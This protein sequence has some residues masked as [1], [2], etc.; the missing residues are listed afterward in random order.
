P[1]R[2][3]TEHHSGAFSMRL[4]GQVRSASARGRNGR[5]FSKGI[6]FGVTGWGGMLVPLVV[7]PCLVRARKRRNLLA[8][9]AGGRTSAYVDARLRKKEQALARHGVH[10]AGRSPNVNASARMNRLTARPAR[11]RGR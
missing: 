3:S 4:V 10:Y 1:S 8:G 9:S 11:R 5:Y 7:S 6:F 2:R